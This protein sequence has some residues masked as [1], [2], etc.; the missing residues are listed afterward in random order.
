[1]QS[2]M[3]MGLIKLANSHWLSGVDAG[4]GG[5]LRLL[6][7]CVRGVG[8]RSYFWSVFSYIWSNFWS[9]FS[10]IRT[11]CGDLRGG[12]PYSVRVRGDAGRWWLRVWALL[13]RCQGSVRLSLVRQ[14]A[15]TMFISNNRPSFHL[16]WKKHLAKHQKVSKYYETDL[17]VLNTNLELLS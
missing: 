5:V 7:H 10:C 9:V 8:V 4:V 16:W 15:C 17:K 14:L 3:N 12:P 13:M 1:M 11:E 6:S 2:C